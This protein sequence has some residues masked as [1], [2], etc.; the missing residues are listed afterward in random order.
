MKVSATV[1]ILHV[2]LF[3]LISQGVEQ[4]VEERKIIII[5]TGGRIKDPKHR[6]DNLVDRWLDHW[7][8][9]AIQSKGH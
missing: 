5:L 6:P 8:K 7:A 4:G 1:F 9:K 3:G 2:T